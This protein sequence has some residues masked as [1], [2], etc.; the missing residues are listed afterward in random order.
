MNILVLPS[1]WSP[2]DLPTIF[3][4]L[5]LTYDEPI[6]CVSGQDLPQLLKKLKIYKSTSEA[7]RAGKTGPVPK[8][9]TCYKA[10]KKHRLYIWNPG[11]KFNAA[12]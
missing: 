11:D 5:N 8:G 12:I 4:D 1:D 6:L 2:K 3:S 7:I 9:Y 10:S